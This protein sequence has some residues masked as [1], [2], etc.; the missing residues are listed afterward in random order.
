MLFRSFQ[1]VHVEE[2]TLDDAS[3]PACI[4]E[5]YDDLETGWIMPGEIQVTYPFELEPPTG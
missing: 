5:V 4:A 1:D 3:I 2:S